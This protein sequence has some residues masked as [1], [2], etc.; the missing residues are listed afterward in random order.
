MEFLNNGT[1]GLDEKKR[2]EW[3]RNFADPEI[4]RQ[5]TELYFQRNPQDLKRLIQMAVGDDISFLQWMEAAI[6]LTP[7]ATA[8]RYPGES[9]VLEP[10]RP[11]FDE[12]LKLATKL[13]NFILP[14]MPADVQ[15]STR[16]EA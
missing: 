7:Y 4:R 10:S 14:L 3:R 13:V 8:Y 6:T 5:I 12:A 16:S 2:D 9:A 11:E 15:P 1:E